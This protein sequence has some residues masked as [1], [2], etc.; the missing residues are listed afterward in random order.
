MFQKFKK[1]L[2][3]RLA[4]KGSRSESPNRER[5]TLIPVSSSTESNN[6]ESTT[7]PR[8]RGS[9]GPPCKEKEED[10]KSTFL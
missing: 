4:K 9:A 7:L 10:N 5:N 1:S 2:S 3:L 6:I 8:R